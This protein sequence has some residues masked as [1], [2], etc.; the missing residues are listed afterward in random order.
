MTKLKVDKEGT[1][2]ELG[3]ITEKEFT[4]LDEA[5]KW[6]LVQQA[7]KIIRDYRIQADKNCEK[8]KTHLQI[9]IN[10]VNIDLLFEDWRACSEFCDDC[11]VEEKRNMCQLQFDIMNHL[12]QGL[13]ECGHKI[14]NITELIMKS[15]KGGSQL[16][17]QLKESLTKEKIRSSY[18]EDLY[19]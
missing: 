6:S 15:E 9:D 10:D 16:L 7:S 12:A 3:H 11:G 13:F 17:K 19:Q 18:S 4:E 8:C 14:N 1:V 5:N 2:G